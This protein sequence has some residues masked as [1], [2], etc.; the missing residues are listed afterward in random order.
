MADAFGVEYGGHV[1]NVAYNGTLNESGCVECHPEGIAD[2]TE[3]KQEEIHGLLEELG[4]L[5]I[6]EAIMDSTGYL[7]G[8]DGINR[9]SSSNPANLTADEAGAFF[10]YK[11]IEED[12]SGGIHNW[13]Y[14]RAL[15]I[16]SKESIE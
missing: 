15:L 9:A 8:D 1:M 6:A 5:L 14:A 16:N 11:F 12:R 2:A 13:K 4:N 10:N 7:L 3:E